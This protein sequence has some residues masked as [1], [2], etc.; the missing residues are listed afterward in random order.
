MSKIKR[1]LP[2]ALLAAL[3]VPLGLILSREMGN[4]YTTS[5]FKGYAALIIFGLSLLFAYYFS[6]V[7]HE[8]GHLIFGL[9]SGYGFSSFR[10]GNFMILKQNKRLMI[11][12]L[13]IAGTGGQCLMCAPELKNGKYPVILYNLG[14][15]IMNLIFSAIAFALYYTIGF[16]P[17]LSTML[18]LTA[19]L[20]ALTAMSNGIPIYAGGIAN[21]GMNAI[22]LSKNYDAAI[23]FRNQLL[24]NAA[25]ASGE[26]ISDMPDEWFELPDGVDMQNVHCASLAVFKAGRYLDR[27]DTVGAERE[28]FALLNSNY[29]IIP[30]HKNLLIC[31]LIYTL[32]ING[33]SKSV[34]PLLTPQ[35]RKFMRSMRSYPSVIRTE[36]TIDLLLIDDAILAEEVYERFNKVIKKFPYPQ[37]I[38]SERML[39]SKALEKFNN[40]I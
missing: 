10:I 37:E 5:P 2:L 11:K 23:A 19:L 16:V 30:L 17:V 3:C 18:V 20:S 4:I 39:M 6:V 26:R 27:G 15:V 7:T 25:Q 40:K 29:N 31:D 13:H 38:K 36:Y 24:I 33:D 1:Y 32:L 21:D 8:G 34:I 28:I 12:R 22:H 14:G 9:I 35:I